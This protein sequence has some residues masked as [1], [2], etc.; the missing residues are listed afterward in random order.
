MLSINYLLLSLLVILLI[1]YT[2]AEITEEDG[3]LVIT[4]ENFAEAL[5]TH[6]SFLLEFYAPWCGHCKSLAPE[7]VKAAK[8]LAGKNPIKLAK[9]DATENKNLASQYDI[10][11]FPSI[12]FFKGGAVEADYN[13]GRKDVDIIAWANKKVGPAT[14]VIKSVEEFEKLKEENEVFV[15][16]SFSSEESSLLK[17]FKEYAKKDDKN[18]FVYS[19]EPS[20][21]SHLAVSNDAIILFKNFDELRADF[22]LKDTLDVDELATFVTGQSIP[23]IQEFNAEA[24]RKIFASPITKHALFFTDKASESHASVKSAFQPVAETFRGKAMFVNVPSSETKVLEYFNLKSTE[25]PAFIFADMAGESGIK[26]Y[27]FKGEFTSDELSSFINSYFEGNLIPFLKS[28][29]IL[30]EDTAGPVK[31]V[32][33]Y[34]FKDIVVNNDKDVLIEFYAPWCGHCKQLAPT[35]DELGNIFAKN[36]NVVIAKMDATANEVDHPGLSVKGFPSIYF[37]KG[38]DKTKPIKYENKRELDDFI[39]YIEANAHHDTTHDEL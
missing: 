26:K 11:G 4:D 20:I 35:W 1:S 7:W 13:G 16:G 3:V 14:A 18:V 38:N 21:Q 31:V 28:E 39:S 12:K 33:G 37:F 30:P 27:V 17:D 10:K 8:A 23:L 15:F 25:L 5:S 19:I 6:D 34:S 2:Y 9:V 36:D 24:S 29:D 32:K 22:P